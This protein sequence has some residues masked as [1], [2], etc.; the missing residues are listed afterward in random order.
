MYFQMFPELAA[1]LNHVSIRGLVSNMSDIVYPDIVGIMAD[2]SNDYLFQII[3]SQSSKVLVTGSSHTFHGS[4]GFCVIT[5]PSNPRRRPIILNL[6]AVH[7]E[8]AKY[9][10][11]CL[12]N[13]SGLQ[14]IQ[15]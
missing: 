12:L 5:F 3:D 14:K 10:R 13:N 2:V 6:Q 8:V 1:G 4:D 7:L 11:N 9:F 15:V